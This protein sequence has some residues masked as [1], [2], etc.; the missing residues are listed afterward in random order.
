MVRV[1]EDTAAG[2]LVATVLPAEGTPEGRGA[3][4]FTN[5]YGV[6]PTPSSRHRPDQGEQEAQGP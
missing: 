2:T 4:E 3:F 1:V 6:N 5:T